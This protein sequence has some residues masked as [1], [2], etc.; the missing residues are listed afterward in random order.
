MMTGWIKTIDDKWYYTRS[1][2]DINEGQ[3]VFGWYKV[4]GKWYYFATDG[5]MLANSMTPDGY[6]VGTDGAWIQ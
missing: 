5:S 1:E 6:F 4:Q 3:M 2:K